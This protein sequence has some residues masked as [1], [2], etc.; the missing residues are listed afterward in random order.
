M[1]RDNLMM[2][3]A[4]LLIFGAFSV[5][6]IIDNGNPSLDKIKDAM[7]LNRFPSEQNYSGYIVEF[8]NPSIIEKKVELEN[9]AGKIKIYF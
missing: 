5:S 4:F 9:I 3:I 7:S 6:G 8:E 1:K 2:L